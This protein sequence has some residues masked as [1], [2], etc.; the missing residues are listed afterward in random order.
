LFSHLRF[1]FGAFAAKFCG[2]KTKSPLDGEA[3]S[4][5]EIRFK[6]LLKDSDRTPALAVG[7]TTTRRTKLRVGAAIHVWESYLEWMRSQRERFIEVR[8]KI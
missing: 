7:G 6:R 3:V 8:R 2:V 5:L 4:G 1:S